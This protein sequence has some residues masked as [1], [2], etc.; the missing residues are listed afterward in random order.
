VNFV[1]RRGVFFSRLWS[2]VGRNAQFCCESSGV[3][4]LALFDLPSKQKLAVK[5]DNNME[6]SVRMIPEVPEPNNA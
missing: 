4:M 5:V 2:G 6:R 3:C 1:A